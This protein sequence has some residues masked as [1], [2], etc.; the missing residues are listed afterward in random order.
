MF[1]FFYGVLILFCLILLIIF[2]NY[3]VLK[4]KLIKYIGKFISKLKLPDLQVQ[5]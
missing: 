4:N 5:L 3:C 1:L 2:T